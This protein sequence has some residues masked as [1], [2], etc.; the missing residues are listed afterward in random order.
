MKTTYFIA[1][2]AVIALQS[3]LSAAE[4]KRLT[5]TEAVELALQ[6]N[7][8][9]KIARLQVQENQAKKAGAKSLY[10]PTLKNESNVLHISELQNISV[11]TGSFGV[12][13]GVAAFP[14]R[15]IV[16]DQGKQTLVTSGTSIVQPLTQLLRIRQENKIVQAEV[17]ASQSEAR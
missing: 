7:H 1:G 9:V 6:Q 14:P 11:P 3:A 17:A 10:F 2:I 16:I 5:I 4:V 13:P 12:I 15:D 8:I